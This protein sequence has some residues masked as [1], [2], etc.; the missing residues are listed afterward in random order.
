MPPPVA[1]SS[2]GSARG[3]S[4]SPTPTSAATPA[5]TAARRNTIR[6]GAPLAHRN[7]ISSPLSARSAAKRS[8]EVQS[9]A[10]LENAA[11]LEDLRSRLA[12][13][14]SAAEAAAEEYAKQVKALQSRLEDALAEQIK[15]EE[16]A[17]QKDEI[18]EGIELQVKELT[19]AKRDQENIYE[20][21]RTAAQQEKEEMIEREEELNTIIQRLKDQ[22]AQREKS[23]EPEVVESPTEPS[24]DE[25]QGFAPSNNMAAPN[26]SNNNLVLQKDK[27]IESLRLE[28]AEAQIRLAEADHQ[29]GTKLQ[30]LEQQLLETRMSNARLMED[31]E[32]FQL[33]LSSA[34][35]NGD[36]PRGDYITNAFSEVE[37]E[38]ESPH[39]IKKVQGSPRNSISL[40]SN[41]AEELEEAAQTL[42]TEKC[43]KLES[44]VKS[45]KDQNKAQSLYIN[46][47]IERILQHKDS[48]AILDKTAPLGDSA[49]KTEKA[50][51]A[52]PK[53]SGMLSRTSSLSSRKTSP[54][55]KSPAPSINGD[56]PSLSRSQ[57]MRSTPRYT[58]KRSHS[59]AVYSG[60]SV[61]NNL[62]R[63]EGM[64]TPRSQTFY[65]PDQFNNGNRTQR[66]RDSDLSLDSTTSE[67]G[68]SVSGTSI[69]LPWERRSLPSPPHHG[70]TMGPIAGNKLRP[71]RLVQ[72]N[73]SNGLV[74]P[75]SGSGR[76]ISGDYKEGVED[77]KSRRQSKR[78]SWI[79][80]LNRNKDDDLH[81]ISNPENV[82]FER[83]DVE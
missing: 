15:M 6:D 17:H 1:S 46:N 44:E 37:P 70:T 29:G 4:R 19:R 49:V 47:I 58:H 31:N 63:G 77:E 26:R 13:S 22:L 71:L 34:A 35:L 81:T 74:S 20:A 55:M 39:I 83:R 30:Q 24:I 66:P 68:D 50:L 57:S 73:V 45:L 82:L 69:P 56:R 48:E 59:D 41:L 5:A 52:P 16:A 76:K 79:P 53:E 61:V 78:T 33:L 21:E 38:P 14:E 72:E 12:Q 40:A 60:A 18:I 32:S 8:T 28:L 10:D 62:Y 36:F 7:S 64:I 80:W 75:T 42:E 65:G 3:S 9:E 51:P 67:S 23:P 43:R 11:M 25:S 54:S 27:L 2:A